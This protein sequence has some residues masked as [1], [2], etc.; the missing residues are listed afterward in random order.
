MQVNEITFVEYCKTNVSNIICTCISVYICVFVRVCVFVH[1]YSETMAPTGTIG[2]I[3]VSIYSTHLFIRLMRE[4]QAP[5]V[6]WSPQYH[7]RDKH[8]R[9]KSPWWDDPL[10]ITPRWAGRLLTAGQQ[11]HRQG[12]AM[13]MFNPETRHHLVP[14]AGR[15]IAILVQI[16]C[17]LCSHRH[18]SSDPMEIQWAVKCADFGSNLQLNRHRARPSH[19]YQ[20]LGGTWRTDQGMNWR[21]PIKMGPS[22]EA[23]LDYK[24]VNKN[25]CVC[26]IILI[27]SLSCWKD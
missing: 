4:R 11:S 8:L 2:S 5:L 9:D 26:R 16:L 3:S 12:K 22:W 24:Q 21:C 1:T 15:P 25:C 17:H 14:R 18:R 13:F 19:T 23:K 27:L 10:N 6:G 7:M 20:S